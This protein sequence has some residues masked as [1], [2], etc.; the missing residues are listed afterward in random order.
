MLFAVSCILL[1]S[2][3]EVFQERNCEMKSRGVALTNYSAKISQESKQEIEELAAMD[4]ESMRF[5]VER[6]VHNELMRRKSYTLV[7]KNVERQRQEREE[8][9]V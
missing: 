2:C 4:G 8:I 7:M 5:A 3:D 9:L 6:A 1:S